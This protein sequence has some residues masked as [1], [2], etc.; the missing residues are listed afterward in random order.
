MHGFSLIEILGGLMDSGLL[1]SKETKEAENEERREGPEVTGI[2]AFFFVKK[3]EWKGAGLIQPVREGWTCS[4]PYVQGWADLAQKIKAGLS[5]RSAQ[6]R[7]NELKTD[8]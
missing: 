5:S 3:N 8:L 1:V 6:L 7:P 2:D 4:A